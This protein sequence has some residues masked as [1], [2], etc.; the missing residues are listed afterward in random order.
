M[1]NTA[2][3]ND[4]SFGHGT[5]A[6]FSRSLAGNA[7]ITVVIEPSIH[8]VRFADSNGAPVEGP[9]VSATISGPDSLSGTGL[10]DT[11]GE[12]TFKIINVA[13]GT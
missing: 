10:T 3:A 1:A 12:V 6:A 11:L 2:P 7:R 8:V 5:A 9:S 13:S 4:L